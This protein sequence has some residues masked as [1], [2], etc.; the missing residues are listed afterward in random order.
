MQI[1]VDNKVYNIEFTFE[2]AESECNN[3]YGRAG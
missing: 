2:A 1:T 3:R